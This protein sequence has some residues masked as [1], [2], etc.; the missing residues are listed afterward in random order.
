MLSK[1]R[2]VF[3]FEHMHKARW[4]YLIPRF[5]EHEPRW[6]DG[7]YGYGGY[8]FIDQHLPTKKRTAKSGSHQISIAYL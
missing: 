2:A 1:L 3:E 8:L 6:P 5:V 7:M 4:R